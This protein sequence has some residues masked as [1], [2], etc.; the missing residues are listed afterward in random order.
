MLTPLQV[1]SDVRKNLNTSAREHHSTLSDMGTEKK[2]K[3]SDA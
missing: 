3:N 2:V 1:H